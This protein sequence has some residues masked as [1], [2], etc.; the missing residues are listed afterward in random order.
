[1]IFQSDCPLE[2]GFVF[3]RSSRLASS[4]QMVRAYVESL[5]RELSGASDV[6]Q[7]DDGDYPVRCGGAFYY[8]RIIEGDDPLVTVCSIVLDGVEGTD[9][10]M[11]AINDIN[12]RL[13]FCRMFHVDSCVMVGTDNV[14]L[15]LDEEEFRAS[16]SAVAA[17]ADH[18]G[19]RLREEFGGNLAFDE[20]KD[21]S[22]EKGADQHTGMY[23]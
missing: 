11:R 20:S 16:C 4:A 7:D 6:V 10:L 12:S 3:K 8:V 19:P 5:I 22:Y 17:A 2:D 14:G 18:F 9:A 15:T 1:M 23:M 13:R 21:G